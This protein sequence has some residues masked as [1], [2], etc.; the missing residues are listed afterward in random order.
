MSNCQVDGTKCQFSACASGNRLPVCAMGF[1]AGTTGG[2]TGK[3]YI[4]T[5]PSD[6]NPA[7]PK[8]GTLRYAVEL[9]ERTSGG[10]WIMFKG[11]MVINLMKK[12][13]IKSHTTIDGRGAIVTIKGKGL[14]LG[15]VENIIIHNVAVGSTGESDTIH[16]FDGSHH[17]W[18]DHV[19]SFDADLGLVTVL[20]GATDVTVSN[21]YLTNPN[22][23]MLLGAS[24]EDV[25]D[26]HLRVT[27]YR[28]W[29]DSSNQRMPHCRWGYCHVVNNYYKDWN[30]YAIGGRAH[31]KILSEQNVFEPGRRLEVTP[32]FQHFHADLTPII[33]SRNDRFLNNATFHQF[34][35]YGT[36]SEPD[37]QYTFYYPTIRST[38]TLRDFIKKCSGPLNGQKLDKC[39]KTA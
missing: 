37:Y 26:Q 25:V 9:A 38:E 36:L 19:A 7:N 15:H 35:V 10:V 18:I 30:Y 14:V 13:W 33:E 21:S 3:Y 20:Q 27:V 4:V 28:N 11:N 2:A 31:A 8:P 16:V 17:V 5:D 34:L 12:L 29:F 24:D 6:N 1:A 39:R 32:W 23:N 22:F